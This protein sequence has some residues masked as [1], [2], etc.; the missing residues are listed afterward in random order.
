[1]QHSYLRE[2]NVYA[3]I[4]SEMNPITLV[5]SPV[6]IVIVQF[7]SGILLFCTSLAVDFNTMG[8][9]EGRNGIDGVRGV[10]WG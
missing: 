6:Y 3:F 2:T 10:V 7:G 9:R 8:T 1:M 4:H 5:R